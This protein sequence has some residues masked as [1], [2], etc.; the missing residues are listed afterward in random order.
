M[1]MMVQEW[2][3][4]DKN[5]K[6]GWKRPKLATAP[7]KINEF[8]PGTW[9]IIQKLVLLRKSAKF[10]K[11]YHKVHKIPRNTAKLHRIMIVYYCFAQ[12]K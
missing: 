11:K 9:T 2:W 1:A 8:D 12:E 3:E 7:K 6:N 5:D 10:A 4:I